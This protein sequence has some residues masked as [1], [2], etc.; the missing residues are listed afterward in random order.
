MQLLGRAGIFQGMGQVSDV[1]ADLVGGHTLNMIL[2]AEGD[3]ATAP[4]L[5]A[6]TKAEGGEGSLRKRRG[7]CRLWMNC[8]QCQASC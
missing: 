4:G 7:T 6:Q 5:R 8:C 2:K 3:A 1:Q